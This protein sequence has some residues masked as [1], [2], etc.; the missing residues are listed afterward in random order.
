MALFQGYKAWITPSAAGEATAL[1]GMFYLVLRV[2]IYN[3]QPKEEVR[4]AITGRMHNIFLGINQ[5]IIMS[6]CHIVAQ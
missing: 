5:M 6:M 1:W 2:G 3:A 4:Y